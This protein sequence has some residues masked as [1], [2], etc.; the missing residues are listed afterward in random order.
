M[1]SSAS[2]PGVWIHVKK[3]SKYT[4]LNHSSEAAQSGL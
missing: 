3:Q 2:K 4:G 1:L